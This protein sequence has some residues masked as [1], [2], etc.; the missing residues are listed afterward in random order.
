MN[1]NGR[2]SPRPLPQKASVSGTL[3]SVQIPYPDGQM[4][5]SES[6]GDGPGLGSPR[7]ILQVLA[8]ASTT[9]H[10]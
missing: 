3:S 7:H 2:V 6:E 8:K 9:Q 5:F 4:G 1:G 10:H